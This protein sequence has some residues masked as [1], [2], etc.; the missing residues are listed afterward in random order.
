[1]T[2]FIEAVSM[3]ISTKAGAV[4]V[5]QSTDGIAKA[6]INRLVYNMADGTTRAANIKKVQVDLDEIEGH[7]V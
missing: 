5:A 2:D 1:M 4:I 3:T 7:A 6:D